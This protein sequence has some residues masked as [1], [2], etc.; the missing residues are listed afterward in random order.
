MNH[1]TWLIGN[2]ITRIK[3]GTDVHMGTYLHPMSVK[4]FLL[5]AYRRGWRIVRVVTC[6]HPSG[7]ATPSTASFTSIRGPSDAW[8]ETSYPGVTCIIR[9]CWA[10]NVDKGGS[11]VVGREVQLYLFGK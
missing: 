9:F 7:N 3:K 5:I 10:S 8:P 2:Q 11:P 4:K 6:V 1:N